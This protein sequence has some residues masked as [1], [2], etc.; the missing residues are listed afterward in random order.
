MSTPLSLRG[1]YRQSADSVVL[2]L[3]G[4]AVRKRIVFASSSH[5]ITILDSTT[6]KPVHELAN[7]HADRINDLC[8]SG[9]IR[10]AWHTL[11]SGSSDGTV[12][13]WDIRQSSPLL[14]TLHGNAKN[15]AS[16]NAIDEVWSVD[17]VVNEK[18]AAGTESGGVVVWDCRNLANST[19]PFARYDVHTEAVSVVKF[20]IQFGSSTD[21]CPE[22]EEP[23]ARTLLT[24]SVDH[25]VCQ[26]DP[27]Q[28]EEEDAV[29]NVLNTEAPVASL[30]F[31]HDW[32]VGTLAWVLSTTDI[33]TIW[34]YEKAECVCKHDNLL[35]HTE[36][37]YLAE[38]ETGAKSSL[39][40]DYVAGCAWDVTRGKLLLVG[41]ESSTGTAHV[42]EMPPPP[43]APASED[44]DNATGSASAT[45]ATNQSIRH[46][47]S[48]PAKASGGAHEDRVRCFEALSDEGSLLLLTGGEDGRVAA[49]SGL[50][51]TVEPAAAAAPASEPT[52]GGK[53]EKAK[54]GKARAKPY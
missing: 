31:Y 34:D 32:A 1:S 53:A 10:G 43:P 12:K 39:P 20:G 18:M 19:Q 11:I 35:R 37:D 54:K 3:T 49:W 51:A 30:D 4:R 13:I 9:P 2:S 24:G 48:L 5:A 52:A 29:L 47:H 40:I 14:Y 33:V 26:I 38:N 36:A 7:A 23:T 41:G 25:L 6:L 21:P 17:A 15:P 27:T 22:S 46:V 44:A 42:F 16:S 28:T 50:A 45:S 8:F